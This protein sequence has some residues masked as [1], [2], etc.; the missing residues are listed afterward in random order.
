MKSKSKIK[1]VC[2]NCGAESPFWVGRCSECSEWNTITEEAVSMPVKEEFSHRQFSSLAP[3]VI[4][5]VVIGDEIRFPSG[6]HE[7]DRILGG[8][9]VR[10]S[11][12]LIGGDPGIGKSTLLLQVSK[13]LGSMGK[14]VLYVSGEE[15]V[16]QVK[17]RSD[18]LGESTSDLY[19][20]SETNM[21]TITRFVKEMKPQILVIDSIQ[22]VFKPNLPSAPGS[23]SQ[24]RECAAHL[25]YLAKGEG[26]SIFLIGHVTKDGQIAGPRVLEHIVDTVLYF[27][28]E[29]NGHYRILRT[30]KN[31][32]GPTNEIGVFEMKSSG[33]EEVKNPS[34]VFL[35]ERT[36][37][38]SGSVIVVCLEGTRPILA[39]IQA[40]VSPSSS[41][42]APRRTT[43]GLDHNRVSMLMAVLDKRGHEHLG[44]QDVF[45][46][47]AGGLK[48]DETASD[49]G[50]LM[51]LRSSFRDKSI[52]TEVIFCAEVGLGGELRGV[53]QISTRLK[54]ARKMGFKK[55]VISVHNQKGLEP[56]KGL[57][58]IAKAN[59]LEVTEIY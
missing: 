32:F 49:L 39:E 56:I 34:E 6:I 22:V 27:E 31:R 18:R 30:V 11:L 42:G 5:E 16:G 43:T 52:E 8:G 48:I 2:Q 26:I 25:M 51:A 4:R 38:I 55:A 44:D 40:L 29:R 53:S 58:I 37:P 12:V 33:L 59:F 36:Q 28:G 13:T 15:S 24:V 10:G 46:N 19:V 14:K 35:S 1:Y 50:V 23:V 54:E 21:E 45:V 9:V 20:V 47:V 7:F 17:M 57:D 41:F 3:K